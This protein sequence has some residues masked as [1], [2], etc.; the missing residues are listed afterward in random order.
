MISPRLLVSKGAL[1]ALAAMAGASSASAQSIQWGLWG[2][3][4]ER[5]KAQPAALGVPPSAPA[6]LAKGGGRPDI[7]PKKPQV[8]EFE[9]RFG[10]GSIVID[11]AQRKLYYTLS[12]REAYVY[13]IAVGKQG[14]AWSGVE[15]VSRVEAWPDWIPPAE[16]RQR[17]PGLPLRMTGG[18]N[19]PLGARAIYLGNTLYRIHGTNDANSIGSAASS[20]CFRMHNAQVVHLASLVSSGTT[21][22]VMKRLPK[23]GP[24]LPPGG[25]AI[26]A[27]QP[28]P[29]PVEAGTPSQTPAVQDGVGAA[30]T[31]PA[32]PQAT[33][34]PSADS[35]KI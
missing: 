34:P 7:S 18:L 32:D 23:N 1:L 4:T 35:Q 22:Y 28:V 9:N 15:K 29:A 21:V 8:V 17:K 2:E 24:A 33:P 25:A 31:K 3:P 12:G 14:F 13:P 5:R 19:N 30:P 6:S 10:A 16:M 20:G 26:A 27:E 11:T